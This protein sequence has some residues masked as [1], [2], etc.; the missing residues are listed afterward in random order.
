MPTAPDATAP[1]D[2]ALRISLKI[3]QGAAAVDAVFLVGLLIALAAGSGGA[4]RVLGS[5]YGFGFVYLLYLAAKGAMDRRWGWSY[6]VLVAVTLGPVGAILGARRMQREPERPAR[7]ASI[8]GR[9]TRKDERKA[10][11]ERRRAGR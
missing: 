2:A 1:S 10:A 8:A 4:V 5:L 3:V 11:A 6:L 7:A 9:P